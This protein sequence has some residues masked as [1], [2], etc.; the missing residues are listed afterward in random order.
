[1]RKAIGGLLYAGWLALLAGPIPGGAQTL[2]QNVHGVTLD[3]QGALQH[4]D[5]LLFDHGKVLAMS[6]PGACACG[7]ER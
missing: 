4:F 6:G 1:M 2:V 5:A 7:N 3:R